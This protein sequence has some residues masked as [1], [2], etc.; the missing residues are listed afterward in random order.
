MITSRIIG[1][2]SYLPQR[3]VTNF[4][5]SKFIDTSDEWIKTRTGISQRHI[6]GNYEFTSNLAYN[7]ALSALTNAKI[8]ELDLDLIIVATTTPD[9]TFPSVAAK[10]QGMLN[11]KTIPAF[12]IQAVCSGFIYGLHIADGLIAANKY[13][14]ILLVCAEKMTSILDWQDRRTCVLFGDGAGAVILQRSYSNSGIIDSKI[15]SNGNYYDALYTNGGAS[16]TGTSGVIKMNGKEVFKH[17]VEKMPAS[18]LELLDNNKLTIKDV[19]YVIPHQANVRMLDNIAERLNVDKDKIIKTIDKHANCSS[20]S[21][22]LALN[23]L[24]SSGKLKN[25]DLLVFTAFAGGFAWGTA[26]VRW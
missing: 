12:D 2:G 14:T 3:I 13:E 23:D 16:S 21:I 9:N 26:L 25:G 4:D 17:G 22:P 8:S 15:Y 1:C 7:A 5:L 11:L 20:A 6:A 10:L 19:A 24:V 18:I